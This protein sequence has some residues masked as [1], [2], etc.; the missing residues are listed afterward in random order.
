MTKKYRFTLIELLIVVA[1]IAI[2]AAMLL[3]ALSK[4]KSKAKLV[5]CLNNMKQLATG[6]Q[7][8]GS[9]WNNVAPYTDY[10]QDL[11]GYEAAWRSR[12]RPLNTYLNANTPDGGVARCPGDKG[13]VLRSAG[14]T[15]FDKFGS[16]HIVQLVSGWNVARFTNDL[17]DANGQTMA[18]R[19]YLHKYEFPDYKVTFHS[20]P[21][22]GDRKFAIERHR[23]HDQ[24][25]SQ[26]RFP[27]AFIDGHVESTYVWWKRG[28]L[29]APSTGSDGRHIG[30]DGYY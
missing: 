6:L 1:I 29:R 9:D 18:N 15:H 30:R 14:Q 17:S 23:W 16:S 12:E 21:L 25:I 28:D 13:S 7:M 26:P 3:P 20:T 5:V 2:L 19:M 27:F 11:V 24:H 22:R 8:Y 4:A 10:Y